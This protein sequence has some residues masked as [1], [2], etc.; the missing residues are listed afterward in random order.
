LDRYTYQQGNPD[1]Q[2][3]FS[4]NIELSFDHKGQINVSANYTSISDIINDVLITKKEPGD[5]NYTTYQTTENIASNKNIGLS[6][7]YN[8]KLN[9]WWSLNVF[10]NV[11]NNH[12]KGVVDGENIDVGITAFNTN[13]SN[14]FT[15]NKGWSAE[16]T[17]W[18]NS[19]N[20]YSGA[21]LAEPRGSFLTA[22]ASRS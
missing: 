5:S 19:R 11:F 12:Y 20:Y 10:M 16:I 15:F 3:Q 9:K 17:G 4:H 6:V 7:N 21:I 2:P 14:Q 1:L 13:I 18:F 22:P 8:R